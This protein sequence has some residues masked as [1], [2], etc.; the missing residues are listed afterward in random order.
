MRKLTQRLSQ[1]RDELLIDFW[2]KNKANYTM[3]DLG[4][5]FGLGTTT[6]W[7]IIKRGSARYGIGSRFIKKAYDKK[8]KKT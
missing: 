1:I 5:I 2:D 4:L 3:K 6:T 8:I 7:E